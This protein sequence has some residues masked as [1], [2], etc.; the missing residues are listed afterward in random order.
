MT[1]DGHFNGWDVHYFGNL[2][3]IGWRK[4]SERN[5]NYLCINAVDFKVNE[6]TGW[7]HENERKG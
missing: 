7:Y 4:N 3:L 2:I 6:S 1:P 5:C